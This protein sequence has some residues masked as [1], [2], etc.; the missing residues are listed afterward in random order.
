MRLI[1]SASAAGAGL[2]A[3]LQTVPAPVAG[4]YTIS[5]KGG[6][7][8]NR[9]VSGSSCSER[10]AGGRDSRR[11]RQRHACHGTGHQRQFLEF[12]AGTS[13]VLLGIANEGL[14]A[15]TEPNN[16]I[17]LANDANENFVPINP[18]LNQLGLKGTISVPADFDFYNLGALQGG[19]VLTI[20]VSGFASMRGTN[21]FRIV[22]LDRGTG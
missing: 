18:D 6:G 10:G 1:G 21:N 16:N 11:P 9:K 8:D 4:T 5:V 3:L 7:R 15:E 22:E 13:E 12:G 2:D 19:D 20:S 17:N 14:A